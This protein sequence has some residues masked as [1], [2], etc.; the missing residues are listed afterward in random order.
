MGDLARVEA[1]TT[2]AAGLVAEAHELL[3]AMEATSGGYDAQPEHRRR[4]HAALHE[5][6]HYL[7]VRAPSH[8]ASEE[9]PN[10]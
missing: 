3:H 4:L 9:S 10:G 5:A 1:L 6:G 8:Y 7:G 2:K